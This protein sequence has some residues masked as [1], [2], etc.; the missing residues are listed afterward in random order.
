MDKQT[1]LLEADLKNRGSK[2]GSA[3]IQVNPKVIWPM[4]GDDG[5]GGREVEDFY[6][7]YEEVCGIA[8][9]GEGMTEKEKLMTL[10]TCLKD[11]ANE[12]MIT[13]LRLRNS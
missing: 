5:P 10:K 4:L 13:C 1:Q 8:R 6:K 2:Q 7:R 9:D 12:F 11:Q 3:V